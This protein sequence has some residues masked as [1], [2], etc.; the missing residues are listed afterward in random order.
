MGA[1]EWYALFEWERDGAS[2]YAVI[3]A[4]PAVTSKGAAAQ[5]YETVLQKALAD[6]NDYV[7]CEAFKRWGQ[8]Q[9]ERA[10]AVLA[11]QIESLL[12]PKALRTLDNPNNLLCEAVS[13]AKSVPSNDLIQSLE[14]V[15]KE[16]EGGANND[17]TVLATEAL[18]NI[19]KRNGWKHVGRA[20]T[21]A[22]QLG[23]RPKK[24]TDSAPRSATR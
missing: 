22:Q 15:L 19:G 21:T 3:K 18:I 4:I 8:L 11:Q 17:A 10:A 23:G 2:R 7:R 16:A 20:L 9:N 13:A 24:L 14:R 6:G 12:S 1:P 5:E